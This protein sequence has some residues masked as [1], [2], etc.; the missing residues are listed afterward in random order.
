LLLFL[1]LL[2]MVTRSSG[3][4]AT[5]FESVVWFLFGSTMVY[6]G[7]YVA[8]FAMAAAFILDGTLKAPLKRHLYFGLAA[9]IF[10]AVWSVFRGQFAILQNISSWEM[11]SA[12]VITIAFIP[13]VVGT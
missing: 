3:M 2:R 12:A 1:H 13:V 4:H 7:D 8:G 6:L 9:L 11:I 5:W 10:T